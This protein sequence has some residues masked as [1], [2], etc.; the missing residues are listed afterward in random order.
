MQKKDFDKKAFTLIGALVLLVILAVIA[1]IV[2]RIIYSSEIIE[3]GN[4]FLGSFGLNPEF[5]R[6]IIG[7]SGIL[8]IGWVAIRKRRKK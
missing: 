7:L 4:R 3:W 5:V 6:F 1:A 2:L 8:L